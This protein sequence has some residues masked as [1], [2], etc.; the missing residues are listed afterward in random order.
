[1]RKRLGLAVL[2]AS[3][4]CG[5]AHAATY[6][7][8][9]SFGDSLSDVGNALAASSPT[10]NPIPL[11]DFYFNGRFSNG[12]N[13]LDDLSAK[14]GLSM[15]PALSFPKP[16]NDF[17]FGGAQ[18]GETIVNSPAAPINLS[19]QV[20]SFKT[21]DPSPTPGALYTL[22][23]GGNDILNAVTGLKNGT[24]SAGD[25]TTTFLNQAV[26][27]TVGAIS[28]LY[29]DGMRTLL[30]Y[31]VPDL[32]V[33]P[34]FAALGSTLSGDARTLAMDFNTDVLGEV[35]ALNLPGLTVFDVPIFS[36]LD[37]IVANPSAFGLANVTSPC[38]SGSVS[39]A[40]SV[41]GDPNSFLFWDGEHPSAAA[42]ALT[43]N[44]AFDVLSGASDPPA[45]PE[46]STCAMMLIGFAGL[47]FAYWR[48]HRARTAQTLSVG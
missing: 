20:A 23:I 37:Q 7:A 16:G 26:A 17:A 13:W 12:P 32:S 11:P 48:A 14:L 42:N 6:P 46:P 28:A 21:V 38:F 40:G 5:A 3:L 36:T 22:D 41:C 43:A 19:D 47:S 34:D 29:N 15:S 39:S 18:T 10:G 27:N 24:I 33:V 2:A 35:K 44:L 8:I 30:Y 9:Y 4:A 1:M 25:L 31:E 45:A